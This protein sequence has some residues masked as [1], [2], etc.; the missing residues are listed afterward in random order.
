MP[1]AFADLDDDGW[2]EIFVGNDMTRNWLFHNRTGSSSNGSLTFEEVASQVG[3]ALSGTGEPLATMGVA[4]ADYDGDGRLDVFLTNYHRRGYNLFQNL[5]KLLF[6]ERSNRAG[7][8][9]PTFDFLGF[10]TVPLDYDLDGWPDLFMTNGHVLGKDMPPFEM[11]GQ[12]LHNDGRGVFRDTSAWAGAYFHDA[13]VGRGAAVADYTNDGRASLAVVHQNRPAALLRNDTR[14]RGHWLGL[15]FVGTRSNR[16]GIGTR[17]VVRAGTRALV[18]EVIG[19]G[20]YLSESDHR[21]LIG[22]G[23]ATRP[24]NVEVRWPSGRIDHYSDLTGDRYWLL[25]E[26]SPP[27]PSN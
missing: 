25:I 6:V 23:N 13:W 3:I 17:V 22:L 19:G 27:R 4:C 12:L 11:R 24:S 26:G 2:P 21:L 14:G 18:H 5:G 8:T 15:Q 9:A 10:G 7:V 16:S 1:I 20:S